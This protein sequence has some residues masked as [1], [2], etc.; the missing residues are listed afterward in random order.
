MR[1]LESG[2]LDLRHHACMRD[3]GTQ[4]QISNSGGATGD[5]FS[6]I[7][8]SLLWLEERGRARWRTAVVRLRPCLI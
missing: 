3:P 6:G 5:H 2:T 4:V 7:S 1:E 8:K